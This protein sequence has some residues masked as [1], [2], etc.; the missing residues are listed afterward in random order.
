MPEIEKI[1]LVDLDGTLVDYEGQLKADLK[2]LCCPTEGEILNEGPL[3]DLED[4]APYWK[5]RMDLIKG[6]PG[7]WEN[8]GR[9]PDGF[10]ILNQIYNLGFDIHILTQGPRRAAAAWSQK[11]VWFQKNVQGMY[12][13]ASI[14]ITRDKGLVYGR[15]L[16]DDWPP[17]VT[18][19]LEHRPRGLVI[20][21]ERP[22]N[23]DFKHPNV[24]HSRYRNGFNDT[25]V[26]RALIQAF[27]R[28]A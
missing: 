18:R 21:P 13:E 7:W 14:T 24:V 6:I 1:A 11:F 17:Y 27:D 3:H 16:V 23:K 5:T 28:P 10:W 8:L 12:P 22:Y 20:M 26:I 25:Q 19:W 9:L 4:S 2:L 15:V